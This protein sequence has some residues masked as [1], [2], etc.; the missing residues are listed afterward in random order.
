MAS[1]ASIASKSGPTSSSLRH[2]SAASY[3]CCS[4]LAVGLAELA[5]DLLQLVGLEERRPRDRRAGG[6]PRRARSDR[7]GGAGCRRS[8]GARRGSRSRCRGRGSSPRAPRRRARACRSSM[9]ARR[10]RM[11]DAVLVARRDVEL[12]LEDVDEL[13]PTALRRLVE[14]RPARASASGSSPR[15]SRTTFHVSIARVGLTELVGREVRDLRADLGL[16]RV[17]RRVL[18]LALVDGVELR[19]RRPAARRCARGRRSRPRASCRARRRCA[20]RRGSRSASRRAASRR[21]RRGARRARRARA[22]RSVALTR[23]SR[24]CASSGHDSSDE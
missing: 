1:R 22:R 4:S 13:R 17:A 7:P 18:E 9:R 11:F 12:A 8:R 15:R 19:A 23:I 5:E 2:A 10:V 24:I 16:G 21:A 3:G 20:G 14:V 6:A